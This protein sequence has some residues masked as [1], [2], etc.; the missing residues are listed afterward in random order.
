MSQERGLEEFYER[1][2]DEIVSNLKEQGYEEEEI[3]SSIEISES[4]FTNIMIGHLTDLGVLEEAETCYYYERTGSGN[5]KVNGYSVNEIEGTVDLLVASYQSD[6]NLQQITQTEVNQLLIQVARFFRKAVK[7]DFLEVHKECDQYS[8]LRHIYDYHMNIDQIRIFFITNGLVKDTSARPDTL[9]DGF[10]FRYHIWDLQRLYRCIISNLPYEAI[11]IDFEKRLGY[12]VPCISVSGNEDDHEI[13][14]AVFPGELLYSLYDEYGGRLLEL[15]VRSFLQARGDVNKGIRDTIRNTPHRF[16]AYNNGISITA[17]K[18]T[19]VKGL[20][21]NVAIRSIDG[22]QVVNGGQTI[23]SIHQ[24]KKKDKTDLSEIFVQ[25]KITK[26]APNLMEEM[27]PN[28]SRFANTQNKVSDSDFSSNDP[29]HVEIQRLS[30]D[31][32]VP[33]E[34]SRWFYERTRGQYQVTKSEKG[35][36]PARKSLFMKEQPTS[37]KFSKTDLAKYLNSWDMLPYI[38]SRGNQKNFVFFMDQLHKTYKKNWK[39][40][41]DYY[42]TLVAKAILF[43]R[44]EKITGQLKFPAYRANVVTYTI[45]YL[46]HRT[47]NRIN[48]ESIWQHQEI[49]KSLLKTFEEWM[50]VIY[51]SIVTTAGERNVTEWCKK[52]ECWRDI[53]MLDLEVPKE[54]KDELAEGEPLPTV[55]PRRGRSEPPLS[56]EDRENIARVIQVP[57]TVWLKIHGWGRKTGIL[58]KWQYGIAHT[59]SGYAS[60]EWQDVP[61]AKQAKHAVAMLNLAKESGLLIE[62]DKNSIQ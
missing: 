31:I 13:Y 26:V 8:M 49:S 40:D 53:Q 58:E 55:G 54:L 4:M 7:Q 29:F 16:L 61:S 37:Q 24:G 33:G 41:A 17:E 35:A 1:I 62:Q 9:Q 60:S 14:L 20:N 56:D 57:A 3:K 39:P 15:N 36:T 47:I 25:A 42:R 28:I 48:F 51:K 6:T 44:V 18:V 32:W 11:S 27:V 12:P 38:V 52:E 34:Q 21:G 50:P 30:E 59:L 2:Q 43:K 5:I 19:V 22:F 10:I 46:A 23:A 45:A